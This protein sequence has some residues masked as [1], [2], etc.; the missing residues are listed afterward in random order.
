MYPHLV[1]PVFKNADTTG[2]AFYHGNNYHSV[3][4]HVVRARCVSKLPVHCL[5]IF[6][7]C[8]LHSACL[9]QLLFYTSLDVAI[10]LQDILQGIGAAINNG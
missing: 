9:K 7:L 1:L 3:A 4:L 10:V 8:R 5:I 6:T 2:K